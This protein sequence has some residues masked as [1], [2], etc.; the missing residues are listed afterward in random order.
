MDSAQIFHVGVPLRHPPISP[1]PS[2]RGGRPRCL[3]F[4][5][6]LKNRVDYGFSTDLSRR[7]TSTTSP[8]QSLSLRER[9]ATEVP[10]VLHRPE[11]SG[12]LWIQHRS[13]KS[14]YLYDIPRSVPLPPGEG[15]DRG[16]WRFTSIWKIESIMDSAEFVHV[17]VL[18]KHP[19]ISPLSLRERARVRGF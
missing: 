11:K 8:D 16:A 2:G 7:R 17:G 4:Y 9:G 12:R 6:D 19:P 10:G 18:L 5:I 13:F 14:A 15:A 3:A 1:S